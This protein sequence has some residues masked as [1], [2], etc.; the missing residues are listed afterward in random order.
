MVRGHTRVI[1]TIPKDT[2]DVGE[3]EQPHR[4]RSGAPSELGGEI[5]G[6]RRRRRAGAPVPTPQRSAAMSVRYWAPSSSIRSIAS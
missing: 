5:F 1:L 3:H 6:V 4:T 2:W